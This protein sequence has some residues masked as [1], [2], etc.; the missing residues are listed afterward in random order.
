MKKRMK[1]KAALPWKPW[2]Q[3]TPEQRQQEEYKLNPFC[4][5]FIYPRRQRAYAVTGGTKQVRR[6]IKENTHR[7]VAYFVVCKGDGKRSYFTVV[8]TDKDREYTFSITRR[9]HSARDA[10]K[11]QKW[12]M[13][14][15]KKDKPGGIYGSIVFQK[16]LKHPPRRWP[17]E[18]DPF[19]VDCPTTTCL[20]C[21][22]AIKGKGGVQGI[23]GCRLTAYA[24]Y[25]ENC[26]LPPEEIA[27]M[28]TVPSKLPPIP[29]VLKDPEIA[30]T[31]D[32]SFD[33]PEEAQ[34]DEDYAFDEE[35]D[36]ETPDEADEFIEGL[37][38]NL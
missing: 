4:I 31:L 38:D 24:K 19:V 18:F 21:E 1:V 17:K 5:A 12:T 23:T 20:R 36:I 22:H 26:P 27:G 6:W 25:G 9:R 35:G 33:P 32:I 34:E 16:H 30:E 29:E 2:D 10:K 28:L 14:V 11:H 3:L 8:R 15:F 7:A 13:Q 37:L